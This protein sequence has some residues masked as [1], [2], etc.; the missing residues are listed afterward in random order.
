MRRAFARRR[1]PTPECLRFA[2]GLA[3]RPKGIY[4]YVFI[5]TAERGWRRGTI[6]LPRLALSIRLLRWTSQAELREP[7]KIK[8]F[9]P[10][11]AY[12]KTPC[13][14]KVSNKLH[15]KMSELTQAAS[16]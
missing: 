3:L 13:G 5:G 10:T 16:Y 7:R 14:A 2:L 8:N 9:T 11:E 12:K 6:D 1:V 4:R 15:I